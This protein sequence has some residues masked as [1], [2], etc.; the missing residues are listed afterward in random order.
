M[1]IRRKSRIKR[2][3]HNCLNCGYE[4]LSDEN[5]CG[6]CGQARTDGKVTFIDLVKDAFQDI[7]NIDS[8]IFL[9]LRGLLRPGRLTKNFFAGKH[10]TYYPPARFFFVTL[11]LHFAIFGFV[12]NRMIQDKIPDV[13]ESAQTKKALENKQ[14]MDSIILEYQFQEQKDS[15]FLKAIINK[16]DA[17]QQEAD[18]SITISYFNWFD[19]GSSQQKKIAKADLDHINGNQL[20]SVYGVKGIE[21][22]TIMQTIRS[23]QN[24]TQMIRFLISNCVWMVL[25]IIPLLALF[26]KLLYIRNAYFFVEHTVFLFHVHVF[27]FLLMGLYFVLSI[28]IGFKYIWIGYVICAGYFLLSMKT[29]YNQSFIKTII[30]FAIVGLAYFFLMTILFGITVLLSIL[31][32]N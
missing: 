32:F 18:D 9:S 28:W 5:Y 31:F 25:A 3:I 6:H 30:K 13:T 12:I 23:M 14:L 24:P 27:S 21:K 4:F 29:F 20:D 19:M 26:L 22:Y 8:R 15:T 7:I 2:I 10:Q 16:R 1:W 11:V 17:F